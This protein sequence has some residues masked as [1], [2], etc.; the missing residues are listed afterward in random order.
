MCRKRCADG[1]MLEGIHLKAWHADGQQKAAY[2][3]R[4]EMDL[5]KRRMKEV[6]TWKGL[7]SI[8]VGLGLFTLTEAQMDA[9]STA[10]VSIYVVLSLLL[11]D[12][13]GKPDA[14]KDQGQMGS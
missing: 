4:T 11:P 8:L 6:S 9:I 1:S 10:M 12:S 13:F 3:W 7:I 2:T 14:G 5:I